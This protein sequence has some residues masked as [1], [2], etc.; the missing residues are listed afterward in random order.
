MTLAPPEILFDDVLDFL[1]AS[2]SA[3]QIVEY[4]PS[5]ILQQHL[6]ELL[7]KNRAGQLAETEQH[8]LEEFMRMNRFMSRLKLKARSRLGT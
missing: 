3:A 8:E 7:E 5:P 6:S 2:P 4:Q 1:A